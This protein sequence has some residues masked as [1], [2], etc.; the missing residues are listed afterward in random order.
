MKTPFF[1]LAFALASPAIP[2]EL[3]LAP[4]GWA[5]WRVPAVEGA[6]AW[7]CTHA[8]CKLDGRRDNYGVHDG[9]TATDGV[10]VYARVSDGKVD[11]L[12]VYAA[13]CP[14]EAKTPIQDL[15]DVAADDSARW[16]TERARQDGVDAIARRPLGESALTALAMHRGDVARDSM[17]AFA[18][19]DSRDETRKWAVF[20]LAMSRGAE[21][22]SERVISEALR[23]DPAEDV[24][25]QAVFALSRLPAERSTKALI[26]AAEDRSL[27]RE[28]R[29]RAVFWLS[30]SE[31][32]AAQAWLEKVL[33]TTA[34]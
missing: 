20:W 12:Q 3:Q 16:L 31:S 17:A 10:K 14:V 8:P 19:Q 7:C 30:Q 33:L 5:G 13:S 28:Q 22:G 4:N 6:P 15:G 1:L 23:K 32:D 18:R 25:E 27:S 26:A 9:E 11:S 24:R 29:K 2:A 34:R 21:A